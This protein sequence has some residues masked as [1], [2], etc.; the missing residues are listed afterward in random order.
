MVDGPPSPPGFTRTD[1]GA[2]GGD[3]S[4]LHEEY[5][6]EPLTSLQREELHRRNMDALHTPIIGETLE[7]RALE[8]MRL[9]NLAEHT[10]LENFQHALDERARERVPESSRR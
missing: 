4:R 8:E 3:P 2:G 10:R 6:P 9:A 5:L 7:A 1:G